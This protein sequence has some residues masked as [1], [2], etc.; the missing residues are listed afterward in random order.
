MFRQEITVA[1]HPY[2]GSVLE[3]RRK[4]GRRAGHLLQR[5][6]RPSGGPRGS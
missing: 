2:D 4:L 5:Q 3:Y 1:K 6:R